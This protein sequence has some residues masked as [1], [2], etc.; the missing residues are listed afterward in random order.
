MT[1]HDGHLKRPGIITIIAILDWIGGGL[2]LLISMFGLIGTYAASPANRDP[3]TVAILVMLLVT[4]GFHMLSGFG[5]WRLKP[6]GRRLQI[7]SSC[8]G[9]FAIPVGTIIAIAILAYLN[10]PGIKL[11]FSGKPLG[12]LSPEERASVAAATSASGATTVIVVL[13][14]VFVGG[15]IAAVGIPALVKALSAGNEASAIASLRA[16]N[17]A[18]MSYA[19]GNRLLYDR[20]DC[21]IHPSDCIA[22]YSGAA[23]MPERL[24]RKRG[25]RFV[26]YP[27]AAPGSRPAGGSSSSMTTFVMTAVPVSR[28]TGTRQFCVDHTGEIRE[29]PLTAEAL[30]AGPSCPADWS[31]VR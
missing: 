16:F 4:A 11:L 6:Y 30:T 7:I 19:R 24:E 26:F 14:L 25:Y 12:A 9:L 31:T 5:L 10:K 3:V 28:A 1:S 27:G 17:S 13:L 29:A 23:F 22:G 18:E 21:L 15:L 20:P 2:W 8:L